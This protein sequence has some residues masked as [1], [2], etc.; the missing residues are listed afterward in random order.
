MV[1]PLSTNQRVLCLCRLCNLAG[2]W[3]GNTL[4]DLEIALGKAPLLRAI[5][6]FRTPLKSELCSWATVERE[7]SMIL[8]HILFATMYTDHPGEFFSTLVGEAGKMEQF[9]ADM[10]C[11]VIQDVVRARFNVCLPVRCRLRFATRSWRTIVLPRQTGHTHCAAWV[12]P[13]EPPE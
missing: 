13:L 9:W 5:H 7:Q 12:A 11:H 10:V 4:R 1:L 8:P 3:A 6:G 2:R